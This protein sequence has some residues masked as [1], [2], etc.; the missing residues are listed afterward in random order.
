[1]QVQQIRSPWFRYFIEYDPEAALRK[2]TCPVLA[3]NGEKDIQVP[4]KQN[5]PPHPQSS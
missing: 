1:M 4:P 2:V 5:L 3:I